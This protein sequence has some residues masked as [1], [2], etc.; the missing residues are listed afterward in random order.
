MIAREH[1]LVLTAL[2]FLSV[3]AWAGTV[4]QAGSMGLGMVTCSMTMGAPFSV[5]SGLLYVILWG[6]MMVA[7]MLPA[8]T[9]IVGLFQTIAQRKREQELPF[10]PVWIFVAGYVALWT[11]TGSIGYA[12]DIA[13]QSLPRQFLA[14]QTYGAII[15]G[16]TLIGAGV[17]QLTPFKYLCLAQCRS[18][19]GFLLTSW[20]D[21]TAGA[22]RMG[23][24]H[25]A[26]CLGC[27]WSLMVVLFVVV[28]MNLLWMGILSI[29]IFVE[30][31]VPR[32]VELGK[33]TGVALIVF[34]FVMTLGL[35]PVSE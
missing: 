25:G 1:L 2:V 18:P 14:L 33:A 17:Y 23:L 3:L 30:K 29:I 8:M 7:M 22:F 10:T 21:G 19:L 28:T 32:G 11:L 9:P 6:I 12:A 20:R 15:G 13:I 4:Y 26:Y 5:S 31:I 35:V 34:G 27:C 16:V 24:H